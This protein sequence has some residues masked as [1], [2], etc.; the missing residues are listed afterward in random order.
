[1]FNTVLAKIR[2]NECENLTSAAVGEQ[3]VANGAVLSALAADAVHLVEQVA[4]R[5]GRQVAGRGE[6][7]SRDEVDEG[8]G[9]GV[10]I[11]A[12]SVKVDVGGSHRAE[13]PSM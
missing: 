2:F 7:L 9:V 12:E 10:A 13:P 8:V 6:Y 11:A 1:M 3:Q 5:I 4:E